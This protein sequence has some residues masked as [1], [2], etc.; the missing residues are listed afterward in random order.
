MRL[1]MQISPN[2]LHVA[3]IC[4]LHITENM[5]QLQC[6]VLPCLFIALITPV[7]TCHTTARAVLVVDERQ[8]ITDHSA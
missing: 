6:A 1:P 8:P 3:H 2:V 7:R 4:Q 5:S